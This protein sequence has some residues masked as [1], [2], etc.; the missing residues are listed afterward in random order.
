M[1]WLARQPAALRRLLGIQ[2]AAEG[3]VYP[4]PFMLSDGWLPAG[5]ATNWW[6]M[7]RDVRAY[8]ASSAMVEACVSAY[9]QT[10][11]MCPGDHW[12]LKGDGGRE[13]IVTSAL[14]R[15]LRYPNE[16]QSISDFLLNLTRDL[17]LQGNAYA[18]ALRN[19]RNEVQELHLMP[20]RHCAHAVAEDGSI[21]YSLAG[22]E[23]VDRRFKGERL[24][25]P[26][27]DVLHVRLHTPNHPLDGKSP[28]L[29]AGLAIAAGNSAVARQ[30]D[31]FT[32][33]ARPSFILSSDQVMTLDQVRM[34]RAAW[35]EQS[36]GMGSGGTPILS[37]GLKPIQVET[38]AVDA[39]L[40][41]T[42]KMSDQAVA[43]AFRVPVQILGIG[44]TPFAS[45]EALM[46]SW[47]AQGL[48]FALNHIEEAFGRLFKLKGQPEEYVEFNTAVLL[49]SSFKERVEA[50]SVG[51]MAGIFSP[52]EARAEFE[53]S[54]VRDGHGELPRM[55]QQVVPL[56]YWSAE[57]MALEAAPPPPPVAPPEEEIEEQDAE[58]SADALFRRI[59]EY[60]RLQ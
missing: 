42:L 36:K 29:A 37:G 39:Q 2:K 26:A 6:Q 24:I 35:D 54:M 13:R 5:S 20:A 47:V 32:R 22:N 18:L 45:T 38:S 44:A 55:Q 43:L 60:S 34:L 53:L 23:V 40:A 4:G 56:D 30:L 12:R 25:V 15:T 27:R 14:T 8:G 51:S 59:D 33:Q 52:D 1:G 31:F 9:S 58:R 19:D 21:F 50:F 3:E 16:Y 41:E 49:R 48:G 46:Q 7:G 17:Y 11:A 10:V 57:R 28:I